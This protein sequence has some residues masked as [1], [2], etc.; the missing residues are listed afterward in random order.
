ME[1]AQR[2]RGIGRALLQVVFAW[3]RGLSMTRL[4]LW[5]PAHNP[6]AIALYSSEGFR[7]TGERRSLATGPA[8]E[9]VAMHA[10]VPLTGPRIP[11]RP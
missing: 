8:R 7:A 5:A 4:G 3:A 1:P 9:I 10:E 11:D 2:R 6:A